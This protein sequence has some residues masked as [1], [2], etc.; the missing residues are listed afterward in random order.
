MIIKSMSRKTV[1]FRQL[2]AYI[3]GPERKGAPLL[4]NLGEVMD[5]DQIRREFQANAH[6]LPARKNGNILFHEVLSF[7]AADQEALTPNVLEALTRH[8]LEIRAPY[9]LGYARAHFDSGNPHVHIVLSANNFASSRRLRLPKARFLHIQTELER[10]QQE[11]FPQ[12]EH[13]IAQQPRHQGP[14]KR[15]EQERR[16]RGPPAPSRKEKLRTLLT[17]ELERA[18]DS[19]D[20][21]RRI[22]GRGL[23]LYRRGRS[24]GVAEK[25]G[26]KYRLK[27]LDLSESFDQALRR[28]HSRP[29]KQLPKRLHRRQDQNRSRDG[30]ELDR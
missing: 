13:S 22:L 28:W 8:Y 12:L 7:S 9:A 15:A 21:Y 11:L 26:R 25:D 29:K 10:Y 3:D 4:H 27:T 1:S 23:K 18:S 14:E 30:P 6:L 20:F 16:R 19:E 17:A 5:P 24:V 2:L